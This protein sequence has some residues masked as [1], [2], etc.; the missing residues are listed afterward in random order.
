M[1]YFTYS[2]NAKVNK[3]PIDNVSNNYSPTYVGKHTIPPAK[4]YRKQ[5]NCGNNCGTIDKIIKVVDCNACKVKRSANTKLNRD[6]YT[7]SNGYL[8]ARCKTYNQGLTTTDYNPLDN[9]IRKNCCNDNNNN[10][11]CGIYKRS[12]PSF[13][14]QGA[15]SSSTRLLRV[16]YQSMVTSAKYNDN[17]PLYHGDTTMNK[18]LL[19]QPLV[20]NIRN[21]TKNK[22]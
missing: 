15:V 6:Y 13:N 3:R 2:N 11:N 22:C 10:Y 12:N 16:K 1:L 20:C 21:G 8:K 14:K 9:S 19:P 5:I 18:P 17:I 7:S 4:Y